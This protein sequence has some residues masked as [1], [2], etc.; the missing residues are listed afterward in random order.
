MT[1]KN[2]FYPETF[3]LKARDLR[4]QGYSLEK[5]SKI[6]N[7]KGGGTTISRWCDSVPSNH[8]YHTR[9]VKLKTQSRKKGSSVLK[10]LKIDK[11][12]TKILAGV[13][14]WCEGAKYP[15]TNYIS[16]T[17]SDIGLVK[18][19]LAL[20]RSGFNPKEN[21][22][23]VC[24]QLH[25]THNLKSITNF[26]SKT[27]NIPK[28]QFYKPTITRPTQNMKRTGYKGTC[29]VRYYDVYLLM[30]MI[31]IFEEFSKKIGK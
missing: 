13:L 30:E 15:S 19:F 11:N 2:G 28:A 5:I 27:L 6:L 31:G 9:A 12:M 1:K 21:K 3:V 8:I 22:L 29:T 20:F 26:W 10:H 17:N 23:R 7:I 18:S 4:K 24:L 14:Y 16:F 25:T